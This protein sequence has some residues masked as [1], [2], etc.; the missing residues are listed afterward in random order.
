[1]N[2]ME[3]VC[4]DKLRSCT[5][6]NDN[7]LNPFISI[8]GSKCRKCSII[9]GKKMR[10]I[11]TAVLLQG[12]IMHY[13]FSFGSLFNLVISGGVREGRRNTKKLLLT[14]SILSYTRTR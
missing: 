6:P 12:Y 8:F 4:S 13:I 11:F 10:Q 2:A 1:M 9:S 5:N 7:S 14:K 3:S